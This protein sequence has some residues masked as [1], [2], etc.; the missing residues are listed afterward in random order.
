M[1][2]SQK[3]LLLALS[4]FA[5][6]LIYLLGPVLTP[7]LIAALLAYLGDPVVDWMEVRGLPRTAAVGGVFVMLMLLLVSLP[8]LLV[9]ALEGQL[10]ALIKGL[11]GYLQWLQEHLAP[12]L[13]Q[14]LGIDPAVLDWARLKTA[15]QEHWMKFGGLAGGVVDWVSASGLA[16]VGLFAN[17]VLVPVVAF[18]LLRDWDGLLTQ[19]RDILPRRLELGTV[20]LASECDEVLGAFLRGQLLVMLALAIVYSLGLW[21]VGL[22]LALLIGLLAGLV[23]FVPYLGFIVGIFAASIAAILQFQELT[24]L[25]P[26]FAVFA[27]G[28]ALEGMV[29]TPKLVGDRIGLHPVAVIFAVMAGGQL[30]GFVGVLIALPVAAVVMVWLRHLHQTYTQSS[31]YSDS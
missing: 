6:I 3:W 19:I 25:L 31:L 4:I 2:D 8:L 20:R 15:V 11:P 17:V 14:T 7:F 26:V 29:L 5:G 22:E 12:W 10:S 1:S 30:F 13:H 21:I 24:Y 9:P 27:V 18:Y 28:Q 23:S 16:L